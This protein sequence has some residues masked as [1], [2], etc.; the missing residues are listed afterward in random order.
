MLD[1]VLLVLVNGL[2]IA[3]SAWLVQLDER[4]LSPA[5]LERAW[6]RASFLIAVVLFAPWCLPIHFVRTRRSLTGLFLGVLALAVVLA[7]ELGLVW[8]AGL[9]SGE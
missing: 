4:R 7:A 6:P 5:E 3:L 8:V 2:G 9:I 1:I